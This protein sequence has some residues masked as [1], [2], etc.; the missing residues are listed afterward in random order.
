VFVEGKGKSP[1]A[2]SF[3]WPNSW[4]LNNSC[5][6]QTSGGCSVNQTVLQGWPKGRQHRGQSAAILARDISV[7]N[8]KTSSHGQKR[9]C[10]GMEAVE[11][12]RWSGTRLHCYFKH[13]EG[14]LQAWP[15]PGQAQEKELPKRGGEVKS[16]NLAIKLH[17]PHLIQGL[18]LLSNLFPAYFQKEFE[19]TTRSTNATELKRKI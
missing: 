3:F 18:V 17:K 9:M 12:G 14:R 15:F 16:K 5:F 6:L 7:L 4:K 10:T 8:T 13:L 19:V 1:F 11:L 2:W